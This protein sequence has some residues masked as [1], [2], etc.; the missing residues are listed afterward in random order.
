MNLF[1][2]TKPKIPGRVVTG[3]LVRQAGI[4][5][6]EPSQTDIT[7][8]M[9]SCVITGHLVAALRC[10]VEYRSGDNNLLMGEGRNEIFRRQAEDVETELGEF[11]S[12]ASIEDS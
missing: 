9:A 4:D 6:L 11:Q 10:S 5:I 1:R 3:I 7:N 8:C 12:A 2:E